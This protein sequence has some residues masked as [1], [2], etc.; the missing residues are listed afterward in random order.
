MAIFFNC[1]YYLVYGFF[2]L[3][4]LLPFWIIYGIS[5]FFCFIIYQVWGYRKEIVMNNLAIA[6]PDKSLAERKK[7]AKEFYRN[8]IDNFIETI[9]LL[10]ISPKTLNKRFTCNYSLLNEYYKTHSSVQAHLG[11]FFN[12]EYANLAFSLNSDYPVLVIYMPLVNKLFN[13]IFYTLRT[14]FNA[15]MIAAT[16]FRNEFLPYSKER[17]CLIFVADQNAGITEKAYWSPF[18]G[19]LAPF[20]TGPEKSARL[21]NTPVFVTKIRKIKRGHYEATIELLTDEPRSLKEGEITRRMITFVETA[22]KEQPANYLWSHRRWKHEF[23]PSR[24]AE[25]VI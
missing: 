14:R 22:I 25:L 3:F 10:S 1:M 9:K 24:H 2:Y 15:K 7:I 19:K 12:W 20:V 13:K 21:N 5:D 18:F 11:H 17:F 16:A 23:D 4:S 6:F 8:L